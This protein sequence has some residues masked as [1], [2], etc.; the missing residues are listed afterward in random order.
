MGIIT[1][2]YCYILLFQNKD[3][4]SYQESL[5]HFV[6]DAGPV[7]KMVAGRKF[8]EYAKRVQAQSIWRPSPF[9]S[10]SKI[11]GQP[12]GFPPTLGENPVP[13]NS[14]V[15][16]SYGPT[17]ANISNKDCPAPSTNRQ[18]APDEFKYQSCE[19]HTDEL[20]S[21]FSLIGKPEFFETSLA[22][23]SKQELETKQG[24]SSFLQ[25][26]LIANSMMQMG[27]HCSSYKSEVPSFR[28]NND[29]SIW[30]PRL[31]GSKPWKEQEPAGSEQYL[32]PEKKPSSVSAG[33]YKNGICC[34][35]FPPRPTNLNSFGGPK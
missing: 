29:L 27:S 10:Q 5:Q 23:C 35:S 16:H 25:S 33:L 15:S 22:S 18:H 21:I 1:Q 8:L 2:L 28:A 26:S 32:H 14:S 6:K 31:T 3:A 4:L 24:F 12:S 34:Y 7:A 19:L 13:S 11:G 30:Q 17:S 20:L 9:G